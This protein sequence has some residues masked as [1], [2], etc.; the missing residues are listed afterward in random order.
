MQYLVLKTFASFGRMLLKGEVYDEELIRSPHMRVLEGRITPA[1][2]SAKVTEEAGSDTESSEPFEEGSKDTVEAKE[3]EK[4]V[5]LKAPP[6]AKSKS[7]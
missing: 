3:P 5:V 7:S 4:A 6:K 2:S 1:V